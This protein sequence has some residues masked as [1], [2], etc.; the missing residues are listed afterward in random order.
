MSSMEPLVQGS[1][2][3]EDVR[4]ELDAEVRRIQPELFPRVPQ[5]EV[6]EDILTERDLEARAGSQELR[7]RLSE[8]GP[9]AEEEP[10]S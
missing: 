4:A 9:P 1:H 10:R 2:V 3:P 8:G 7:Q 6:P 5:E